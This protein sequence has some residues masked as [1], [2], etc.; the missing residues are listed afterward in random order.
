M[1]KN[2][3]RIQFKKIK[4]LIKNNDLAIDEI[5]KKLLDSNFFNKLIK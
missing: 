2:M 5:A 3:L 4:R 1:L